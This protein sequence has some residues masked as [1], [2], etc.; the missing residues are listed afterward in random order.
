LNE[1]L[2]DQIPVLQNLLRALEGMAIMTVS[3]ASE[4]KMFIVQPVLLLL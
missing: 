1:P 2:F 3:N 4:N